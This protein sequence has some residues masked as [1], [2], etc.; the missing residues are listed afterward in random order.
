MF[1]LY[2]DDHLSLAKTFAD[3]FKFLYEIYFLCIIFALVYFTRKKMFA[4]DNKLDIL[5]FKGT[6]KGLR[7]FNKY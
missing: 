3:I 2:I 6:G 4:F 5:G 7:L 1:G